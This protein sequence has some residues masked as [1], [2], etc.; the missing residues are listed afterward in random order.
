MKTLKLIGLFIA[1]KVKEICFYVVPFCGA[2]G[3]FVWGLGCIPESWYPYIDVCGFLFIVGVLMLVFTF[4]LKWIITSNWKKAK[5]V[6][7]KRESFW[8]LDLD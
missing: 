7:D 2:V 8:T 1:L 3:L 5:R 4:F 6:L